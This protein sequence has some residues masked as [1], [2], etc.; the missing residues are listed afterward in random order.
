M[1]VYSFTFFSSLI[2]T[3][4]TSDELIVEIYL[5]TCSI[6]LV[7]STL[8]FY[9]VLISLV[10]VIFLLNSSRTTF[11]SVLGINYG[12]VVMS[13]IFITNPLLV[14]FYYPRNTTRVFL[15]T[16]P[17]VTGKVI[18]TYTALDPEVEVLLILLYCLTWVRSGILDS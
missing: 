4:L 8:V 16:P 17:I 10:S 13:M 3:E 11:V 6:T 18:T 9:R 7:Y 12:R 1:I 14:C 2:R 15:E 5:V